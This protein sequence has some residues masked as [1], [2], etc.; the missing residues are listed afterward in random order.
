MLVAMRSDNIISAKGFKARYTT[1]CGAR[2]I[3]KDQGFLVPS[4]EM[5]NGAFNC[6]WILM[7]ENPA[8]HVTVTFTHMELN[9]LIYHST[10]RMIGDCNWKYVQVIEG[11]DT[12]GPLLGKW[13]ANKVPPPITSTGSALTVHLYTTP[14]TSA[15]FSATYSVLNSACGGNYTSEHGTI[16]SPNYPNSYPLNSECIWILNTSPGNRI[17]ITFSEFDIQQSENCDLDYLEIREE[18]GIGKLIG[19]FC[20][21][22]INSVTSSSRIW[23]KFKSDSDGV[24][25]GFLADY[26]FLPGDELSGPIGR[27]TSPLY[28]LPYK[29]SGTFSW[30]ITVDIDYVIRLELKELHV[31]NIEPL[32]VNYF[33]IYDGYNDE[34]P[35]LTEQCGVLPPEPLETSSNVAYVV[36]YTNYVR[37][38][39]W[40][41]LN[42]L[43]IPKSTVDE[44]E[45]K[46]IK[47]SK[48][49]EE[50]SLASE[51]NISYTFWSPGWPH[52]YEENLECAWLFTSPPGTHLVL[53]ITSMNLEESTDCMADYVAVYSGNA[54]TSTKNAVLQQKLCL[55]NSTWNPIKAG[56]VMTVKFVSDFYLNETGFQAY[57]YRDCGGDLSG[58]DGVIEINNRTTLRR[59]P[60][61]RFSC[62]WFVTVKPGRTI[63]VKVTDLS[64][65]ETLAE[66]A[67]GNSYILLKN[68]ADT[69]SPLLG[70]GKYCG[71]VAP[72]PLETTGNK[73]YVKAAGVV[74]NLMFKLTYREVSM[75][76][77]G[78]YVLSDENKDLTI[79]T[80]NYPNIPH[81]YTECTWRITAPASER[82]SIHFIERFD[83]TYSANCEREYVELRDGGTDNSK[84]MG[85]YC[86]D[87]APSSMT[88]TGNMM[89][90]HF[91]T[92]V[93]EPKNGF[94]AVVMTGDVCGGIIRGRQ[95]TITSPD[96]PHSYPKNQMCGWWLIGPVDHSLKIQFR[97]LHLPIR[98]NC[99]TADYVQISAQ[100]PDNETAIED[101]GTFCGTQKPDIIETTTN[102]AFVTFRS[103]DRDYIAFRG[104]S[105]N[106][107]SSR[108]VCGGLLTA[109]SG[110]IKSPGYPNPRTRSRY[111]DWRI[112]LPLGY[113]V[114]VDILDL[115]I[116]STS[117]RPGYSLSFYN[118][119]QFKT[120]I[121]SVT[122][123]MEVPSIR[124][125]GNTM[126]IGY[127]AS[128]GH[129]GFKLRYSAV[130][131]A[132]CGGILTDVQGVL[133]APPAPY[134]TTS[135]MCEWLI[136][137]PDIFVNSAN[138]TGLTLTVKVTGT[139][140]QCYGLK[141]IAIKGVGMICGNVTTPKYLR[142]PFV[143]NELKIL[144]GT[145]S[146]PREM[147]FDLMY[148][149]QPCGG[150]LP[151]PSHTISN[152]K[153]LSYPINCAWHVKYADIG[154]MISLSF[155]KLNLGSC[156]NAYIIIRNGGPTAPK[157]GTF[158]GNIRPEN[159]T[160]TTNQLWIEYYAAAAPNEFEI[161]L[162]LVNHGCGGALRSFSKE[163]ASP[164]FPKQYPNKAECTWEIMAED[165][166][167]VGLSFVSRF[168]LE[169]SP[170]CEKDYVQIFDWK[171]K[172][173][174]GSGNWTELGKVCGREPPKPFNSTTNRMKVIFRSNENVQ[175]DGFRAIWKENCGGIFYVTEERK[176]IRSPGYPNLYR[177]NLY[178][179]YTL[180][181]TDKDIAVQFLDFE[182]ERSRADCR[183]DNVT[184]VKVD[185]H[186]Y[187]EE[188]SWCGS[189]MPPLQ[190]SESR[191]EI[192]LQT[193]KFINRHGFQFE[194][195]ISNCG[196]II[197]EPAEI[198]PLMHRNEYFGHLN[199]TWI[200][201]APKDKNVILRFEEFVV[202]TSGSCIF[203]YVSVFEG[204]Y[205][206]D[207]KMLGKICGNLTEHLPVFKSDSNLMAINFISDYS[208][209][210]GGFVGK[211]LFGTSPAAGCG[212]TINLTSSSSVVFKTQ[213]GASYAS[214]E[215]CHWTV[216]ATPGKIIQL[217]FTSMD[218]KTCANEMNVTKSDP[219]GCDYLHVHD[220]AGQF[221]EVLGKYCGNVAPPPIVSSS[222][223]LWIRFFSDGTVEG[224]GAIGTLQVID[225][226]CGLTYREVNETKRYITSPGY[227]GQYEAG[228]R[229]RWFLKQHGRYNGRMQVRLLDFNITNSKN[230]EEEYLSITD[231]SDEHN[232]IDHGFGENFVY[233]GNVKYPISIEMGSH[234]PTST[235]KFCGE[236][237]PYDYYSS[238]NVVKI[239]FK[240][241]H[242]GKGFKLEYS[243]IGCNRN[244]TSDETQ[245]RI[246]HEGFTDCWITITTLPNRT[247]SMYFNNFRLYD[248]EDCTRNALQVREGDFSGNVLATLCG[249]SLP[250]PVFSTGNKLSLHSWTEGNTFYES[251]DITY[252]T[253]DAG[254]GCGGV[255]FNFGG[256]FTSPL[257][258]S[259]YRKDSVCTWDVSV[260]RGFKVLLKFTV[261]DI[262]TKK[263]CERNNVKIYDYNTE[264]GRTLR[265]TY[266]GGDDPA[267]FEAEGDKILVEYSSTMN[268]IG[269]GW[270]AV[271][272]SQHASRPLEIAQW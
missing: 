64:T 106:F 221:A 200:V 28:P 242:R 228:I 187:Q 3:V 152:P 125:S 173:S 254:R 24:G 210:E 217:S 8:D 266:C 43:Q 126:M 88:T 144:N 272:M 192:I 97:D 2:I 190:R 96:Y 110:I 259:I 166:Y 146:T 164:G 38:G 238:N 213:R 258:P 267:I 82:I 153:N 105:L 101:L 4:R 6:T 251:Y 261:F 120:R 204:E 207:D 128:I 214:F 223:K 47:L 57:V 75:N 40:F 150:I 158:C 247:I 17:S 224:R 39:N 93:A 52:G 185:Q 205:L 188:Q 193:D 113:Q 133:R 56:N 177:P 16:G 176:I 73:L 86:K 12:N 26:S 220:G 162:Q 108:E 19:T 67:C 140:G 219:C 54:L 9:D 124:S 107:T 7:A 92:D 208:R 49:T 181:S 42:W 222:N 156:E 179:N 85:K 50:V 178:C 130:A 62:E 98:R 163:I 74:G 227:P 72:A 76:C 13:C 191:M 33:K 53:R 55:S 14:G 246:V 225:S 112:K 94:K 184:I 5:T 71:D 81:P 95:G 22:Q 171:S 10:M 209:H 46:R 60:V 131:P 202:E 145:D 121:R 194:Y 65:I 104:F 154:E 198:S 84:L 99:E 212:G 232:Y 237:K 51:H 18:D 234:Y 45:A 80:P 201:R 34:A 197:T 195:F 249:V 143:E 87:T 244:Y 180:L 206:D 137:A 231:G 262:G 44:E 115:G 203:D 167:H 270:V 160:S 138:D 41:D 1:A 134:N 215:D 168:N 91:Y 269:T 114:V 169:S 172:H 149:W 243:D 241:S 236:M 265:N 15:E 23:I 189:D 78:E 127:W 63:E 27:I 233:S 218:I 235:Y 148:Q 230:C 118:D 239:V 211:I 199:C 253:T 103:D 135:Y 68:G 165:G 37:Y 226:P 157:F 264:G 129:R 159:I 151:G 216:L 77:G 90:I 102:E 109:M 31:E 139:I 183:F 141:Q 142:S 257:Y 147:R 245:G 271:F 260:P 175:G 36:L 11:E 117:S 83:L 116:V 123:A 20:G 250:N 25:K 182:I 61:W 32:C 240:S 263:T 70:N 174:T 59:M 256:T 229:C 122:K 252:V 132:P 161:N 79:S 170:N 35:V 30:R 66:N 48:C 69:S 196:G 29:H 21:Q 248:R 58:P 119:F 89:Y 136:K 255:I 155:S 268:N 111:C 100:V 186:G